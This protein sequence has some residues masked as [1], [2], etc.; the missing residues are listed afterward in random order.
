M[1]M[2]PVAQLTAAQLALVN[3]AEQTLNKNQANGYVGLGSSS[4]ASGIFVGRSGTAAAINALTLL[5]G[6]LASTTDTKDLRIGDGATPGGISATLN[7]QACIVVNAQGTPTQNFA[8]VAAAYATAKTMTPGGNAIAIQNPVNIIMMPG[9]YTP[10]GTLNVD[11][12]HINFIGIGGSRNTIILGGTNQF[13]ITN[14]VV[15]LHLKGLTFR[16]TF[17]NNPVVAVGTGLTAAGANLWEDIVFDTNGSTAV[18]VTTLAAAGGT[19]YGTYRRIVTV[20]KN[21]LGGIA[22]WTTATTTVFEDCTAGDSAF[23]GRTSVARANDFLGTLRRCTIN[24]SVWACKLG[25]AA[26]LEDSYFNGC[27]PLRLTTGAIIR[28]NRIIPASGTCIGNA[29]DTAT[30][31]AYQNILKTFSGATPF[32]TNITNGITTPYNVQDDNAA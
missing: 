1:L 32:G 27:A 14:A 6:E 13:N 9:V 4:E 5:A 20:G 24:S 2:S 28:R 29:T 25:A 3:G 31:K 23:L 19:I 8:A 18:A 12:S 16:H 22:A 7:S 10:S 30:V 15:G 11:T 17:D 21:F 26:V